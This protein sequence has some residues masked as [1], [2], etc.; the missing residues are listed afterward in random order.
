MFARFSFVA[1]RKRKEQIMSQGNKALNVA[2]VI[3]R[4]WGQDILM[5]CEQIREAE[6]RPLPG[7][8][9]C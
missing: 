9:L 8:Q 4:K 2:E 6:S 7:V 3:G 1:D 5:L